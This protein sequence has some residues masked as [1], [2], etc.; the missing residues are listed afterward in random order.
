M[1]VSLRNKLHAAGSGQINKRLQYIRT[2]FF[3]LIEG[4]ST[5]GITYSELSVIAL[6]ELEHFPICRQIAFFRNFVHDLPVLPVILVKMG[7]TDIEERII[8]K[9]ERL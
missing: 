8:P 2:I 3:E 6:D 4:D 7:F 9:A 1:R 5:D